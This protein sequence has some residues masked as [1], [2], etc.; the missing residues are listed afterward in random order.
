MASSSTSLTAKL[1]FPHRIAVQQPDN[2]D[3]AL[4]LIDAKN[5]KAFLE[6]IIELERGLELV[7]KLLDDIKII[8]AQ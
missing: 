1:A 3:K 5:T 8:Q 6:E 7:T 2:I 4:L